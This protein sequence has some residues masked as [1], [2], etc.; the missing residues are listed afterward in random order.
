M[1]RAGCAAIRSEARSRTGLD[2][3]GVGSD[4]DVGDGCVFGLTRNGGDDSGVAV[5]LSEFDGAEGFGERTDPVNLN[6]DGVC[7]AELDAFFEVLDVGDEEV[8]AKRV[9]SGRR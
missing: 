5:A 8:V 3:S 9:G 6:E 2:L 7:A 4:G 1:R